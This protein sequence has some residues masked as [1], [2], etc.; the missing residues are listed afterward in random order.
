MLVE[1]ISESFCTARVKVSL[2]AGG[3]VRG[4]LLLATIAVAAPAPAQDA[5]ARVL[6][7]RLV[8][9]QGSRIFDDLG[10]YGRD[11]AQHRG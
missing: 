3:V 1:A 2:L 6:Q 7:Q 9:N 4:A 5:P 8:M 11:P 10:R